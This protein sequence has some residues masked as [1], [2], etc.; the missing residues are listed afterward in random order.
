MLMTGLGVSAAAF[1]A[2]LPLDLELSTRAAGA[3]DLGALT[4]LAL[5]FAMM[6]RP[7]DAKTLSRK[8]AELDEGRGVMLALSVLGATAA[9]VT[10]WLEM[11]AAQHDKGLA[12][13]LRLA[14]IAGTVAI[15][16][17]FVHT[18]FTLHYA[19]EFY[20]FDG[21]R[22]EG[23]EP[24]QE[25]KGAKRSLRGGLLFPGGDKTPDYWD[26]VHFAFV[27][28][29]ANQTADVQIESKTIRRAVTLHGVI[30]FLFNTVI[31]ATSVNLAAAIL[32]KD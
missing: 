23:D 5:S 18:V 27:I 1:L 19:H 31:L 11:Q 12:L 6:A 14:F 13:G 17:T 10:V 22:G 20:G 32:G 26:F 21:G 16:W 29:V 24:G 3:W 9:M 30:A 15:C 4:Y 8:S 2:S 7:H 28:G 25:R